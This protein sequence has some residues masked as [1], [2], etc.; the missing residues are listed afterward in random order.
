MGDDF[1]RGRWNRP[2]RRV[3][4][5]QG[6][7][8]HCRGIRRRT[9]RILPRSLLRHGSR[10]DETLVRRILFL[11]FLRGMH[12]RMPHVW[13]HLSSALLFFQEWLLPLH[14][15][16]VS[17]ALVWLFFTTT[18]LGGL[19][20][21]SPPRVGRC[22]RWF[23]LFDSSRHCLRRWRDSGTRNRSKGRDPLP[24]GWDR[25]GVERRLPSPSSLFSCH[26]PKRGGRGVHV[27][28]LSYPNTR[29]LHTRRAGG[30]LTFFLPRRQLMSHGS[31]TCKGFYRTF[32]PL[33]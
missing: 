20:S 7:V 22:V 12:R 19:Q 31:G 21:P 29:R 15:G 8:G 27:L 28:R 5:H 18:R 6:R 2:A 9:D 16:D 23:P 13:F 11:T 26:H 33:W 30:R 1:D 25:G 4:W 10:D 17:A 3:R 24:C 14:R 32:H